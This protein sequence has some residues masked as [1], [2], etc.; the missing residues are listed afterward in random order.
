MKPTMI[1]LALIISAITLQGQDNAFDQAMIQKIKAFDDIK[2][3]EDLQGLANNFE[4]IAEGAPGRWEPLYYSAYSYILMCFVSRNLEKTD[5]WLDKAQA[6]LDKALAMDA[7]NAELLILQGMLH[8]ARIQVDPMA[9]GMEYSMKAEDAFGQ[10]KAIDAENPRI[11]YLQGSSLLYTP[12]AFGG[13]PEAAC[14]LFEKAIEKYKKFVPANEIA[15]DWGEAE[16]SELFTA[17]CKK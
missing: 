4:R 10:A 2:T 14:P 15:P 13:G 16:A 6:L 8:Q 9:R 1:V 3:S 12:A 17:N 7:K 11:Y 5:P